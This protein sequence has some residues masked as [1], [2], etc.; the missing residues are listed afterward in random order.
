[1]SKSTINMIKESI[2]RK[3][4]EEAKLV[5]FL[6]VPLYTEKETTLIK[7]DNGAYYQFPN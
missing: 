1:M 2:K 3:P 4:S 6:Q 5:G 7:E